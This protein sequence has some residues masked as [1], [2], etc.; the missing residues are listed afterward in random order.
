VCDFPDGG[1]APSPFSGTV[2]KLRPVVGGVPGVA[3]FAPSPAVCD[4]AIGTQKA[5]AAEH[6]AIA[7]KSLIVTMEVLPLC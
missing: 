2:F 1:A 7:T 3:A 6:T 4:S 5:D